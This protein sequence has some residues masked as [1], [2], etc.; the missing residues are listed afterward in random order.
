VKT[1][2]V[3]IEREARAEYWADRICKS[4]AASVEQIIQTG[5]DL[6]LAKAK[7]SHGEWGRLTG[8]STGQPLLSFSAQ[9]AHKYMLVAS[10]GSLSNVAHCATYPASWGTLAELAKLPPAILE[11]HITDGVIHP[12]LT[13]AVAEQLVSEWRES[14]APA[15]SEALFWPMTTPAAQ[16]APP[17]P[18]PMSAEE[19]DE[20][21]GKLS[22]AVTALCDDAKQIAVIKDSVRGTPAPQGAWAEVLGQ[23]GAI[24]DMA[25]RLLESFEDRLQP[26]PPPDKDMHAKLHARIATACDQ[27][28]ALREHIHT[29]YL[30]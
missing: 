5:R 9:T 2:I 8:R 16:T 7:L 10:H 18:P 4:H 21:T 25:L 17:A 26:L 20:L 1:N 23:L 19:R 22:D 15:K 3:P 30:F 27:V 11:K 28:S 13:R 12:E 24:E 14:E 6:L 29:T